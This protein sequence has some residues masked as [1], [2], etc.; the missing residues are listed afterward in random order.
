MPV[1]AE[2]P[3]SRP[4]V[5]GQRAG[6]WLIARLVRG[7]SGRETRQGRNPTWARPERN[8]TMTESI[9]HEQDSANFNPACWLEASCGLV[10]GG[11]PA[12]AS[13]KEPV[14][15]SFGRRLVDAH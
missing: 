6:K 15:D 11:H 2:A 1:L 3:H 12:G 9:G 10:V 8:G 4:A 14:A 5:R 13:G 7:A